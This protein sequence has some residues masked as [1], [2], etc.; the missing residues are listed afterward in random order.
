[1]AVKRDRL[2]ESAVHSKVYA[3]D[4]E[5]D[6][7]EDSVILQYKSGEER[8]QKPKGGEGWRRQIK[9]SNPK[10]KKKPEG[11]I[12]KQKGNMEVEKT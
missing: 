2:T 8:K 7:K 10:K 11:G 1:M 9:P 5:V 6:V 4:W 3:T 12:N